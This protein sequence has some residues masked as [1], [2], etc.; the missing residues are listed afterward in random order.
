[1]GHVVRVSSDDGEPVLVPGRSA[2]PE[3]RFAAELA[4]ADGHVRRTGAPHA[5]ERSWST[6]LRLPTADGPVWLKV[7]TARTRAE[8]A[9][10][11]L[12]VATVPDAVVAPLAL[13]EARGLLLLP[14]RVR[15]ARR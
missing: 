8:V 4:W 6:V 1:M 12:L 10:H 15:A 5:R 9:L 3:E 13:D 7:T 14:D 11:R 2:A